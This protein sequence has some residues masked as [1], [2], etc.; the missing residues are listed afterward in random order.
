MHP[1]GERYLVVD[2]EKCTGCR[3]CEIACSLRQKGTCSPAKSAI[4][5]TKWED[6]GVHVPIVCQ[7]CDV[8]L[9]EAVC[10]SNAISRDRK[11]GAMLVDES[12]CVGC[13]MC[14][15]TCPFGAISL[16]PDSRK[17]IKCNLCQGDPACVRFCEPNAIRFLPPDLT[18]HSSRRDGAR[19]LA[20]A[21]SKNIKP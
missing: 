20:N 14:I 11:T 3:T 8:P 18:I 16:D 6:R 9:C 4:R 21:L 10:P 12:R 19:K 13:Q 17:S 5:I 2:F 1:T 7:Q 15:A